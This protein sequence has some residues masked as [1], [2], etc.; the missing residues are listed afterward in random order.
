M[1]ITKRQLRK[2]V[3]EACG[4]S[5]EKDEGNVYG[6][7]GSA[8]MAKAQLF[9]IATGA[10]ELHDMLDEKDE[11]PEWVQSKIAVIEDNLD[12]VFD[13]LEYKYRDQL[14]GE[15]IDMDDF[16]E[17]QADD[18]LDF[19]GDVGTLTPDEAFGVGYSTG[20]GGL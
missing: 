5:L 20:K 12:A 7:G 19:A 13:H 10:A 17:V 16:V 9:Q 4:V 18:D 14:G 6:H 11:L 8:R 2:L 1:K 3:K 15:E